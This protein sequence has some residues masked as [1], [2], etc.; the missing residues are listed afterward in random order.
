MD[1]Q[2]FEFLRPKRAVLAD[3]G[4]FAARY[5]HTERQIE[6]RATIHGTEGGA[7]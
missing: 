4:A 7:T 2:N 3:L 5:A 1:S 6:A